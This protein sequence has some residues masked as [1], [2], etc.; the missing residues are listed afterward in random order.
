MSHPVDFETNPTKYQPTIT[1]CSHGTF[2]PRGFGNRS[3][4]C[5][6]CK[7][8][9]TENYQSRRM[10]EASADTIEGGTSDFEV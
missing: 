1:K 7:F 10:T 4:Y 9:L 8:Q 2:V 5:H 3:P 6:G